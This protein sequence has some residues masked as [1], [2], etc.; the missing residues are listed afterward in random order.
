MK[1]VAILSLGL[2]VF[3]GAISFAG[4]KAESGSYQLKTDGVD[5]S[6]MTDAPFA[7]WVQGLPKIQAPK[8]FDWKQFDGVQ[9][10]FIS[11]NTPPSSALAESIKSFEDVTGIK[12]NIEQADLSVVVEKVALD[13]N[14]KSANYQLVYDDPYQILA[15]NYQHFVN[16]NTFINNKYLPPIPGGLADF[17]PSQLEADGYMTNRDQLYALPYDCPTMILAYRTDVF[18]KYKDLFMKENG[19]DWTPSSNMTWDQYYQVADWINKK[20]AAGV[21]TEVK[22]GTGHQAK[23]YDSLMCDFSNILASNGGDYFSAPNLGTIGTTTPGKSLLTSDAAVKSAQ[24]YKKLLSIAAPGSTSWDWSGVAEAFAAGDIAM[25]PEWHEFSSSFENPDSSKIA[26]KVGWTIL[27]KG[28]V[29]H[30]N[31]YG[32][33]GVSISK[34]ATPKQ[35]YAAWLFLVWATSPQ[36][37]Y[38]ILKSKLGGETPVRTSVYGLPD[39]KAGM[40]PNTPEAKNM[41]NLLPMAATLEAWKADNVYMRPK[42][43][44]WPQIDTIVYTGLSEMLAGTLSPE[45]AMKSIANKSDKL[46]G[47]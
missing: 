32:G 12:V 1:K 13:I 5:T 11:E 23:Q 46:T 40:T 45:N 19:W 34:Y 29:R 9:L 41:P 15:K 6:V 47:N 20:V 3:L 18:A 31:I 7:G 14:A 38:M 39:V 26:G 42:I 4:G 17:I 10:N 22:Y 37:E 2:I 24:F 44:Q 28:S 16:L 36:A 33:T 35:Q 43:P 27:P 21:I 30:A 8:G 25:I